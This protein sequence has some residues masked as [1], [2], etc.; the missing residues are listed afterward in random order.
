M[1][2]SVLT[3]CLISTQINTVRN[4][5][6]RFETVASARG[7]KINEVASM[8]EA[9]CIAKFNGG[10]TIVRVGDSNTRYESLAFNEFLEQGT[11]LSSLARNGDEGKGQIDDLTFWNRPPGYSPPRSGDGS[12]LRRMD[13][14]YKAC[15]DDKKYACYEDGPAPVPRYSPTKKPTKPSGGRYMPTYKPTRGSD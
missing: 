7:V 13:K 14:K 9:Q 3:H 5:P 6:G 1:T 10:Q 2:A 4:K 15:P 11:I 12:H 8:D